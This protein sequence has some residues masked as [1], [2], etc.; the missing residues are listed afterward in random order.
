MT[1]LE[2]DK[3]TVKEREREKKKKAAEHFEKPYLILSH[4]FKKEHCIFFYVAL[5]LGWAAEFDTDEAKLHK[6]GERMLALASEAVAG[7][8]K[9]ASV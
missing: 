8:A 5:N 3:D 9:R 6:D 4:E 7:P 1:G 2:V